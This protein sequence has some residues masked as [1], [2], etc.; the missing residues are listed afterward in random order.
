[1]LVCNIWH[2]V[3]AFQVDNE[4]DELLRQLNARK[5][6]YGTSLSSVNMT[7]QAFKQFESTIGLIEGKVN[8]FVSTA[9]LMIKDRHYDSRRIR[10]EVDQIERKWAAFFAM[11]GDYRNSL[12]KSA[13]YF[14]VM[15]QVGS[16]FLQ[17]LS[18]H[19]LEV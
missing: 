10:S 8:N 4:L 9:D 5:G 12:N 11:I 6:N 16:F 19:L 17:I 7:S 15:E 1:M 14:N 18:M 3:Y 13:E 2:V